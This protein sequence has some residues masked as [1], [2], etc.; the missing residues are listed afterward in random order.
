[1][2]LLCGCNDIPLHL[3]LRCKVKIIL[4]IRKR[5]KNRR[6]SYI[7]NIH[8]GIG[9]LQHVAAIIRNHVLDEVVNSPAARDQ[10]VPITYSDDKERF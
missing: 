3:C 7:R 10:L 8:N 4:G 6:G 1:M 9:P 2:A 5:G